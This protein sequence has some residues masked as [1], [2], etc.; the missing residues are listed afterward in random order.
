MKKRL[1]SLFLALLMLCAL[2]G[3]SDYGEFYTEDG[4]LQNTQVTLTVETENLVAPVSELSFT[5]REE[6]D[7]ELWLTTSTYEQE[8][9]QK[10]LEVFEDG[11][12][13]QAPT[14]G[15]YIREGNVA[16][17]PGATTQK[18]QEHSE[19]MQFFLPAPTETEVPDLASFRYLPL[20]QGSYRLRVR[21]SFY[22]EE[23]GVEIP[24][25]Q[26]EAVAYFTVTAPAE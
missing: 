24:E 3:C 7:F 23:Q 1:I 2:V 21:Y 19:T 5:L 22:S 10:L 25:G 17:H 13:K 12:W 20:T 6:T 18:H 14:F 8:R 16:N 26:L 9:N 4:I 11:E 15:S